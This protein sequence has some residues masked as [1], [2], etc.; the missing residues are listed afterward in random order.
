MKFMKRLNEVNDGSFQSKDQK[1]DRRNKLETAQE[2]ISIT[3]EIRKKKK[4]V[5]FSVRKL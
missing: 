1:K 2:K 3:L 4:I 5:H